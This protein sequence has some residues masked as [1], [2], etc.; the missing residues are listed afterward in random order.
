MAAFSAIRHSCFQVEGWQFQLWTDHRPLTFA[1]SRCTDTWTLQQK[2]QLSYIAE[3]TTD[4]RY[5]SCVENVVVDTLSRPP[6]P[7][8][9]PTTAIISLQPAIAAQLP[10]AACPRARP[11]AAVISLQPSGDAQQPQAASLC[12]RPPAAV[13]SLPLP[14]VLRFTG[15]GVDVTA[16]AASRPLCKEVAAMKQMPSLRVSSFRILDHELFWDFSTA[17]VPLPGLCHRSYSFSSCHPPYQASDVHWM[18]LG[19]HG[20]QQSTMVPRLP[21]LSTSQGNQAAAGSSP[22]HPHPHQEIFSCPH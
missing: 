21:A 20:S 19:R 10:Q 11:P 14:P 2:R 17:T 6:A 22:A 18:G 9:Q 16:L 5:I 3:Y 15:G 7:N 4:I 12:A 13:I 8:T 1:L